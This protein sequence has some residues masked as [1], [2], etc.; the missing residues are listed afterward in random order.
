MFGILSRVGN[1]LGSL[2]YYSFHIIGHLVGCFIVFDPESMGLLHLTDV[3]KLSPSS[4]FSWAELAL[5]SISLHPPTP[6]QVV[7]L[8]IDPQ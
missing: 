6:G 4:S 7:K 2:R 8:K 1:S 3:A 5:I